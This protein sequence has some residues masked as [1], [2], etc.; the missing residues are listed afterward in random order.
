M[1]LA[2]L[3]QA[4]DKQNTTPNEPQE[5]VNLPQANH[6]QT[7]LSVAKQKNL[8]THPT[9]LGL[10]YYPTEGKA[11]G[12]SR[13]VNEFNSKT[14][15][16]KFF[17]S[18]QGAGDPSAELHAM[19]TALFNPHQNQQ[20]SVQCRFPA[21]THW[22]KQQLSLSDNDIPTVN[23][24]DFDAW[25]AKINPQASSVIFASEYL[26]NP[27]SAFAHSFL[28]FDNPSPTHYYLNYTPKTTEGESFAKFAYK[29][30][31]GG[32]AGEFTINDYET[33]IISYLDKEGRDIWQYSLNL[34]AEQHQQLARQVYEIKDQILPYY[35]LSDN[36][37]SEILELLNTLLPHKNL[38]KSHT[39]MTSPAQIMRAL[40]QADLV[41]NTLFTPSAITT[42]QAHRNQQQFP[43]F[44]K[45][46]IL[47]Q[48]NPLLSPKLSRIDLG[49]HRTE[50]HPAST[51]DDKNSKN[52]LSLGYRMVYHD[53]LDRPTG[54]PFGSQVTAL[55]MGV[56]AT[57]DANTDKLK[58]DYATLLDVRLLSPINTAKGDKSKTS[59][60]VK[61][62]LE[63][64]QDGLRQQAD[65]EHLVGN[66]KLEYG[67]ALGY[68]Q[69]ISQGDLPPNLCYGLGAVSAQVGK[70]LYHG[71]RTGIG[72]NV[73]CIQQFGQN[74]RGLLELSLPYW[75]SGDSDSERYWQPKLSL[76][77]QF[78][79]T[80]DNAVRVTASREWLPK[81]KMN[82]NVDTVAVKWL[83][84]FE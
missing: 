38:L 51:N 1:M 76:G 24:S 62:G 73:G 63:Q 54:Y 13:V 35:L 67:R 75:V 19:L 68:G 45:T 27:P 78:D 65:N 37:A 6:L 52:A 9:W 34:T 15:Q 10:L 28:R 81:D 17:V 53:A 47:N 70:G 18:P 72:A 80:K 22:L 12:Q 16:D 39:P 55:A 32:N 71:Y 79:V 26:N 84:Y 4:N 74:W 21:R 50:A 2:S 7:A 40:Q 11:K 29:S 5:I 82:D 49:Y 23:C 46:S 48:T 3:S 56:R 60:G 14:N 25:F 58:L 8:A 43:Q 33:G 69:P 64:V 20:N 44:I 41:K 59:W 57:D 83:H 31:I 30:S 66:V 77:T 36:C 61:V 42:Q